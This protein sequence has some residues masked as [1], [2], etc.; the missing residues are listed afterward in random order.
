MPASVGVPAVDAVSD[1]QRV[2]SWTMAQA[3]LVRRS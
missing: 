2:V 1:G 3:S